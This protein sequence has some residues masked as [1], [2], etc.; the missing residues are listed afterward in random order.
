[1]QVKA[2][3]IC[4]SRTTEPEKFRFAWNFPDM[5][6]NRFIEHVSHWGRV[7]LHLYRKN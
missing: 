5:I 1:M 4:L 2:L 3:K 7:I 6:Q